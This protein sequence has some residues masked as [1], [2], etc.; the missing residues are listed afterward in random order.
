MLKNHLKLNVVLN[1]LQIV[2][3]I[4]AA[5]IFDW[6]HVEVGTSG[7]ADETAKIEYHISLTTASVEDE[8]T[9]AVWLY[10][11]TDACLG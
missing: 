5:T 2:I 10:T 8:Y 3:F 9:P 4:F 7:A 1:I 6:T 11:L